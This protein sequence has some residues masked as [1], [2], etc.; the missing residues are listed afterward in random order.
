MIDPVK[1]IHPPPPLRIPPLPLSAS[2]SP[3]GPTADVTR[4][5]NLVPRSR[6]K[7]KIRS[8]NW[9]EGRGEGSATA[10]KFLKW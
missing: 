2:G 1:L 8:K 4:D 5:G 3:I 6:F 10:E 7:K 9:K